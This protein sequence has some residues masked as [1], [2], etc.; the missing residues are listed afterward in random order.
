MVMHKSLVN[1]ENV[2]IVTPRSVS[3]KGQLRI[4]ATDASHQFSYVEQSFISLG[5]YLPVY[6]TV[7]AGCSRQG[8]GAEEVTDNLLICFCDTNHHTGR[9]SRTPGI[10]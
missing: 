2:K 9:E 8:Q 5:Q 10:Y 1:G 7:N 4:L 6:F 3:A